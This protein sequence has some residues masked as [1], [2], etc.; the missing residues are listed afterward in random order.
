MADCIL[1]QQLGVFKDFLGVMNSIA[2]LSPVSTSGEDCIPRL[3]PTR[4]NATEW[5]D[6]TDPNETALVCTALQLLPMR[7]R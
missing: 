4:P 2:L 1:R 3:R 6:V 7:S 5:I